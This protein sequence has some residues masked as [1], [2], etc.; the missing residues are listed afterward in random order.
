MK[1]EIPEAICSAKIILDNNKRIRINVIVK[2]LL[3]K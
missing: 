2:G 3:K 1:E